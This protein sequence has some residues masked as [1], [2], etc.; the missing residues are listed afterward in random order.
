M[1]QSEG[2]HESD[3][4]EQL[5]DTGQTHPPRA[6]VSKAEPATGMVPSQALQDRVRVSELTGAP[7]TYKVLRPQR[8]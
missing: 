2:Q 6:E 7:G 3:T 1:L 8:N 4:T 5:D